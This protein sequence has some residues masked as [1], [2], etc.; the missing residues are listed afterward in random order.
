MVIRN[1]PGP[2]LWDRYVGWP[3]GIVITVE[4][5]GSRGSCGDTEDG[6]ENGGWGKETVEE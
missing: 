3:W 6:V 5:R 4:I 1:G 2:W